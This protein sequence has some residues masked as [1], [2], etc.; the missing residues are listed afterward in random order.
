VIRTYGPVL[1][2]ALVTTWVVTFG[3]RAYACRRPFLRVEPDE[4][5]IHERTTPTGGGVAM[6]VAFLVAM[7]VASRLPD[8]REVFQGSTEPLGVILG[9]TILLAVGLL[10]DIREVSPPAKLAG[11]ILGASVMASQGVQMLYFRVPFWDTVVLDQSTGFLITV[12][13]VVLVTE[14]VNLIDGLDGLAAGITL[15]AGFAF[16]LYANRQ[17]DAGVLTGDT[18]GPLLAVVMVGV[19]LGFLPHNF[20]PAKVFMGDA[21]ALFLGLLLATSTLVVGGRSNDEFSG[22]TFFFFAPIL[23]PFVILGVPLLDTA[24]AFLRRAVQR[25]GIA[26]ADKEHLHHR[27][28]RLGHGHRRAVLI[29]WAWTA[30]LATLVLVP[31]YARGTNGLVLPGLLALGVILYTV[32][33]PEVRAG[34]RLAPEPGPSSA[35][36]GP[37][38]VREPT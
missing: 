2:V 6:W 28:V 38:E 10:D 25:R 19:C 23:I 37:S 9:A 3:W 34:R 30:V 36:A 15:I 22:Q 16:F 24:F 12:L 31:T 14:A 32:L 4:R 5:R 20:N 7:A 1:G 29:L 13:W 21:G 8:L 33:H 26:V 18:I 17:L 35:P 11:T 27:L